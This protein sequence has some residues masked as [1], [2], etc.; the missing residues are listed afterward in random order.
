MKSEMNTKTKIKMSAAA[1]TARLKR[2][3]GPGD[4]ER[5]MTAIRSAMAEIRGEK[6]IPE[7]PWLQ[8]QGTRKKTQ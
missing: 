7:L 2:A 8:A 3:C 4:A 6:P 5:L 1:V